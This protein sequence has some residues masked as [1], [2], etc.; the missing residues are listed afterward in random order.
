MSKTQKTGS[1]EFFV[2]P[3]KLAIIF[4]FLLWKL[5]RFFLPQKLNLRETSATSATVSLCFC[6]DLKFKLL[7]NIAA[8]TPYLHNSLLCHNCVFIRFLCCRVLIRV[9]N[10]I[11]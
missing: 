8:Q 11:I 2:F 10:E 7:R 5:P 9:E 3:G 6:F 1:K 4:L